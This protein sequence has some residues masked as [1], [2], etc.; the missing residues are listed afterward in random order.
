MPKQHIFTLTVLIIL[1]ALLGLTFWTA[2]PSRA[3]TPPASVQV[4]QNTL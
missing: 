1:A 2:P 3:E 4:Q